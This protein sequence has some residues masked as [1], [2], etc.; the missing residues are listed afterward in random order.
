MQVCRRSWH[1]QKH[2]YSFKRAKKEKKRKETRELF[3]IFIG[4]TTLSVSSISYL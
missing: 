3:C 1:A 2:E 4:V